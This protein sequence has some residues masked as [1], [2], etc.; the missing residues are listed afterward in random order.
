MAT[1]T[2]DKDQVQASIDLALAHPGPVLIDFQ[3]EEYENTF[4]M[5]P[6]GASL[7]ETVDSPY[8][9]TPVKAKHAKAKIKSSKNL[10]LDRKGRVTVR[11]NCAGDAG[12][13]C[14][15]TVKLM[16]GKSSFGSK[17]FAVKAGKTA[18]VKVKVNKKAKSALRS[19][20]KLAARARP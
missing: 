3:V 14:R 12:A 16:R 15:G 10:K 9:A 2:P 20:V 7:Q 13:V 5:V 19:Q 8:A 17:K 11:V 1:T 6:P 18:T 4:P